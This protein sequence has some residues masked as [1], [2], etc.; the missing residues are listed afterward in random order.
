MPF[1]CIFVPDFP[2][3]AI[4]RAE[5][6]LRSHSVAVLEGKPP[7]EKVLAVNEE[8]RIAG[9]CIGMTKLQAE[10]SDEVILRD[11][12]ELQ[13]FS[14][15]QALLDCAQSFSPRIEDFAPDTL[16]L[17]LSGLETLF[18]SLP[19]I[20]RE[21]S[22]CAYS[23][24]LQTN[25]AVASTLDSALL[26]AHGFSG[27]TVIPEGKESQ[28]LGSLPVEVLFSNQ[29]DSEQTEEFLGT[30]RRWGIHKFRDLAALP[31]IALTERLGQAGLDLQRKARGA[32]IRDLVPC[33][34]PLVFEEAI[35]VE[36]PIVLL[37]PLAF[38]LNRMLEQLCARLRGRS[39]AVQELRLELMLENN[40]LRE[41]EPALS[42]AEGCPS[43][44]IN[45]TT[46]D[47][48]LHEGEH[49]NNIGVAPPF[50]P[51]LAK[52][53][54]NNGEQGNIFQRIIRLPVPLLDPKI[55]LKL[56]QLDLNANPPGAPITKIHLRIEP[57][58]PR[59]A[60]NGLFIPS[61]PEP[62]KLELTLARI[63][64][65]VGDG[66]AGSPLLLDTHRRD[67]FEMRHFT[68]SDSGSW[69][70]GRPARRNQHLAHLAMREQ[71]TLDHL[72]DSLIT[73]LRIFRPSI[74]VRINYS[75]GHLSHIRSL[76]GRQISG[77]ILWSAGPWRSSGDWWE[78]DE[79]MRDEWD[80]AVQEKD[81][82][83]LYRLVHDLTSGRWLLEGSYD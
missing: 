79:W 41:P 83:V 44:S 18:G 51:F 62:E 21:I 26:A 55:F 19:K 59:P 28:V 49:K 68:P 43:W 74:N 81:G 69:G 61:S 66:R 60:Q 56:L 30:F 80:I 48:K 24:G 73:A 47:T 13:E 46:K 75:Q 25:V 7:L 35:E 6:E 76:K 70:N 2:A 58:K 15:H 53:G 65:I 29:A 10:L 23:L 78:H 14:A 36:Y 45:E 16:L 5:P 34:P 67:A 31:E 52:G 37:E 38:L 17:D 77:D 32:S 8:A 22:C 11:R 3:A 39:L 71:S 20:A 42:E 82:I 54:I 1:A 64:G 40:F 57:A 50:R 9:I 4:L 72:T 12:S 33:D 27:V 63:N